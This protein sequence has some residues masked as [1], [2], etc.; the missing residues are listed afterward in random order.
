MVD[1][2]RNGA[3]GTI[4]LI[5]FFLL[6]IVSYMCIYNIPSSIDYD[7]RREYYFAILTAVIV[8]AFFVFLCKKLIDMKFYDRRSGFV[9]IILLIFVVQ[10]IL[11]VSI[12]PLPVWD[13]M[14]TL[15][16]AMRMSEEGFEM[17]S[18][19]GYFSRY[20]NNYPFTILMACLYKLLSV[21]HIGNYWF[22]S[23]L[24]NTVLIDCA[25]GIA[26][27]LIYK[28]YDSS[29]AFI[30]VFV[31]AVNPFTYVFCWYVYTGTFS[32]FFMMLSLLY[33][34]RVYNDL[35]S[36]SKSFK[37]AALFGVFAAVG[38]L[39]RVT[40]SFPLIAVVVYLILSERKNHKVLFRKNMLI[41]VLAFA[42]AAGVLTGS[43][44]IVENGC[45]DDEISDQNFPIT[46]WIAMGLNIE[47]NGSFSDEDEAYTDSFDGK[48]AKKEACGELIRQRVIEM[49]DSDFI[50]I[51]KRK[52][53][54]NWSRPALAMDGYLQSNQ[55]SGTLY[56]Y[57]A[58]GK[59]ASFAAYFQVFMAALYLCAG[60]TAFKLFRSKRSNAFLNIILIT[61]FGAMIFHLIWE[62]SK[63]Y[64]IGFIPFIS[65][66]AVNVKSE[67]LGRLELAGAENIRAVV[68]AVLLF[69]LFITF[70]GDSFKSV[71]TDDYS[72]YDQPRRHDLEEKISDS[73]YNGH[74]LEGG[75]RVKENMQA[76][77][78]SFIVEYLGESDCKYVFSL[79]NEED[80]LIYKTG[81]EGRK[82]KKKELDALSDSFYYDIELDEAIDA[83]MYRFCI[84]PAED[85]NKDSLAFYYCWRRLGE[86]Y[87]P[88]GY[89][90]IDGKEYTD[91]E[92]VF[93]VSLSND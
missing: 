6:L 54:Y 37:N 20:G 62:S 9:A 61:V 19:N 75:F 76:D 22:V 38:I 65:M 73:A 78:V 77:T 85:G 10:I 41:Y 87:N 80:D 53:S 14:S 27:Y 26:A 46:H 72:V 92:W 3:T 45:V 31:S 34:Y 33:I 40:A 11:F 71:N 84:E 48:K 63:V 16:E 55:N 49:M 2:V 74:I 29:K 21:L 89:V 44:K 13:S 32:C 93:N 30:F 42:V 60:I 23:V 68:T 58:G 17:S 15:E 5:T 18:Q 43:Y 50:S 51:Y 25:Y 79:Y 47:T 64:C 83:G 91:S 39:I 4:Q 82:P 86:D 69:G 56:K 1:K 81:I 52:L 67:Q 88:Y 90:I 8:C 24:L 7:R 66:L 59:S 36:G 70:P 35:K 12:R 57:I 28:I